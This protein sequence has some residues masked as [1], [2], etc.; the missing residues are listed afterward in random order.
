MEGC[1]GRFTVS[2]SAHLTKVMQMTPR[3]VCCPS[4]RQRGVSLIETTCVAV[5]LSVLL[6][7]ALPSFLASLQ[8]H[9]VEGLMNQFKADLRY[10]YSE[11]IARGHTVHV[12]FARTT[13]GSCYVIAAAKPCPCDTTGLAACTGGSQPLRVAWLPADSGITLTA[14]VRQITFDGRRNTITPAASIDIR[15]NGPAALHAIVNIVGRARVCS[16]GSAMASYPAC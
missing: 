5:I 3:S 12:T 6:G 1:G 10:G 7:L 9:R 13:A 15:S 11:A 14:N 16:P 8:R 4:R 2:I